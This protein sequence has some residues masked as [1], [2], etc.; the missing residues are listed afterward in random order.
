MEIWTDGTV[1]PEDAVV[2]AAAAPPESQPATEE[3]I[4]PE[5]LAGF[6]LSD[7][8]LK[9]LSAKKGYEIDEYDGNERILPPRMKW[10]DMVKNNANN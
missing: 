2:E 9:L 1:V 5:L 4:D 3:A 10:E 8:A 7:E 6:G